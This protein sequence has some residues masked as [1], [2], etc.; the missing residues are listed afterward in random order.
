MFSFAPLHLRLSPYEEYEPTG[1][2]FFLME[3][4]HGGLS[5]ELIP[6]RLAK[7]DSNVSACTQGCHSHTLVTVH[8]HIM[9]G[10]SSCPPIFWEKKE[11]ENTCHMLGLVISVSVPRM[12]H[13]LI[14]C[15]ANTTIN[16]NLKNCV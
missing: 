3:I 13:F 15:N 9:T 7:P 4:P 14:L 2:S 12:S 6:E 11:K 5:H 1:C 8:T 10:L 16:A